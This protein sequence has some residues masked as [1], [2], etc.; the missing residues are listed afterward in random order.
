MPFSDWISD[1]EA[2][3]RLS[4]FLGILTIM[5]CWER[6]APKRQLLKSRLK[7]WGTNFALVVLNSVILR[8]LFPTAAAGIALY[9]QQQGW[10]LFNADFS[11]TW[12]ATLVLISSILLFDLCIYWQHRL[13]HQVPVLWRLH[14]VHHA[15]PDIDVSTGARF[16]PIEIIVSM[17]IKFALVIAL[18]MPVVAVI[19]FEVILNATS[20]FNHSNVRLPE[21]LDAFVRWFLVTPDMHRVH[22]SQ[23][24]FETNSNYG[25]NIPWWDKIFG[26]YR[27]Q[28]ELG[29]DK[30]KIGLKEYQRDKDSIQ[31]IGLLKLPFRRR[32]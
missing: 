4:A 1:H 16:H 13:M 3:I 29:H 17:L 5:I 15:D 27:A 14:K 24:E 26:S 21:K 20:M 2:I 6:I 9:A 10:G 28:P 19:L 31:I 12:P 22:H 7:R 30:M 25:F 32:L 11:V 23:I 18:G 8:L